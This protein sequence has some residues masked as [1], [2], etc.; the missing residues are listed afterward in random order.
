MGRVLRDDDMPRRRPTEPDHRPVVSFDSWDAAQ[1]DARN[2]GACIV[3][4]VHY[5]FW[6]VPTEL[7]ILQTHSAIY[8]ACLDESLPVHTPTTIRPPA[9]FGAPPEVIQ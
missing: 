4:D 9:G 7:T 3:F 6:S 2:R 8:R 1:T 5:R